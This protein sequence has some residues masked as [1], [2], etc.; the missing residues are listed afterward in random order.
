MR[1]G[2]HLR[3]AGWRDLADMAE[4]ERRCFPSDAWS[5][6]V[7]WAE[8]AA[9][10]TRSYW[11][12][13]PGGPAPGRGSTPADP[14]PVLGYAG[15]SSDGEVADVMTLAVDPR[16]RGLGWGAKLLD[17]L[18]QGARERGCRVMM[19]E[20]RADHVGAR[21][22]YAAA[23]YHQVHLRRGYYRS[24]DGGPAVDAL[25]LRKELSVR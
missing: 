3:P 22:L 25:V 5:E 20:V 4:L 21:S 8:L 16:L 9:R 1:D 18:H 17:R 2:L 6:S 24:D 19:L 11:V 23:G 14:E 12:V 13:A 15:L 7:F 10:P